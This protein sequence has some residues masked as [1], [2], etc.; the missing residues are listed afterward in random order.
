[1]ESTCFGTLLSGFI[2]PYYFTYFTGPLHIYFLLLNFPRVLVPEGSREHA[3]RLHVPHATELRDQ[4]HVQ[5]PL[6]LS[7]AV[8]QHRKLGS[9]HDRPKLAT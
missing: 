4:P 7:T 1:M 6:C 2:L 9:A 3:D 8:L 5:R